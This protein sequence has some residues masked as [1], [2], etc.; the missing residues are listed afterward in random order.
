MRNPD[1]LSAD[2]AGKL[3]RI[4]GACPELAAVRRHVGA[5]AVMMRDRRGDHLPDWIDRARADDLPAL[6]SFATGLEHDLAAVTAGLTL[7]SG[8]SR[9]GSKPSIRTP[10]TR[11]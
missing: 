5:F 2:D 1:N 9:L 8:R 6:H 3:T 7:P 10:V 11:M 4:L